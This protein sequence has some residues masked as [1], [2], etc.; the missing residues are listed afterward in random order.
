MTTEA[1]GIGVGDVVW[2]SYGSSDPYTVEK[3]SGPYY[4]EV[5][6]YGAIMIRTWPVIALV[7]RPVRG[8]HECYLNSIR[9]DGIRWFTDQNDEVFVRKGLAPVQQL[10]MFMLMLNPRSLPYSFKVGV[11][12]SL[13][14][15]VWRCDRCGDF[16]APRPMNFRRADCVVCGRY[17]DAEVKLMRPREPGRSYYSAY[18]V[19]LG[20]GDGPIIE[21]APTRVGGD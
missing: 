6:A 21:I 10:S 3:I 13:N 4:W 8:G 15:Q 1:L 17:A 19:A 20:Y 18:Q 11:D 9:R 5:M 16:N 12:Y 7:C 2:T 14:G